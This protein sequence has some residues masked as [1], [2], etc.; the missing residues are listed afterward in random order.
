MPYA[1]EA[2]NFSI[3]L[4]GD[5]MLTRKLRVF[6]EPEFL[7]LAKIF[8]DCDAGM[9]N[10]ES[11]VR[12]WDEGTPG[13]TTG[14]FMTTP[15]ELLDEYKWFGITMLGCAN[16]HAF[17][18]GEGGVLATIKHL[19]GA[20]IAHAGSGRNLAEAR[21]PGYLD[22]RGGRVAILATTAAFRPW[23][24]A[25]AQRP[26][27]RGRPGINP[28]GYKN[29]HTV[30]GDAFEQLKRISQGL[31]FEQK[32]VRQRAHFFSESEA[33]DES[34]EEMSLLGER[35]VR[36]NGFK[37][38]GEGDKA[39]IEGNLRAIKEARR[40]ADWVVVNF[41]THEYGHGS[42]VGAKTQTEL[43]EPAEFLRDFARAAIDAG[44]DIFVGH[45]S[46]TPL[47]IE[48]HKGKPIFHSVGSLIFQNETVPFFPATA[49]ERFGLGHDATPSD[50]LDARTGNGK[51]GHVAHED[52]W[53]NIAAT[54]HFQGGKLSEIRIHPIDL[55]FGRPRGQRGRPVL[56]KGATA[57]AVLARVDKLSRPYGVKVEIRN[58]TGIVTPPKDM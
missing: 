38:S 37:V 42:L 47:G 19:D 55:G 48:F 50:F 35:F 3:A 7:A 14:T 39:D 58:G 16:N 32:R 44:A 9:G 40:Q 34:A 36:G 51:K 45:G 43:S 54:C 26:D 13:I 24:R 1:S 49:Y 28:F 17:D 27:L 12:H 2:G 33:P 21:M 31:G 15:P 10:L 23:N 20:G 22:T 18:Y 8:R 56:A 29:I 5:C 41:H 46:H 4:A 52:Y 53:R 30:D 6:D 11:V 57:E 25:G